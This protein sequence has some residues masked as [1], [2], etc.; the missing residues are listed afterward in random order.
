[1]VAIATLI[2]IILLVAWVLFIHRWLARTVFTRAAA[3]PKRIRVLSALSFILVLLLA[4]LVAGVSLLSYVT[5]LLEAGP[6]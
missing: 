1:M 4:W 5:A 3:D 2:F 6:K